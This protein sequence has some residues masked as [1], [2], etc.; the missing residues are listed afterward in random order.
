MVPSMDLESDEASSPSLALC[1]L[2]GLGT[3][4]LGSPSSIR[5][6]N[7][8]S[9]QE[10]VLANCLLDISSWMSNGR[11]KLNPHPIHQQVPVLYLQQSATFQPLLATTTLPG[12]TPSLRLPMGSPCSTLPTLKGS[13]L[14]QTNSQAPGTSARAHHPSAQ[15]HRGA[16]G[17]LECPRP[18]TPPRHQAGQ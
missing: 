12:S 17:N 9:S 5:L 11:P 13:A 6:E 8:T 7:I 1:Q 18:P 16:Q 2:R 14:P 3:W 10:V 15:A 4:Q